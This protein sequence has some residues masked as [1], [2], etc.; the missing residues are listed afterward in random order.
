MTRRGKIAVTAGA[1]GMMLGMWALPP[2]LRWAVAGFAVPQTLA[3]ED[4]DALAAQIAEAV[5]ALAARRTHLLAQREALDRELTDAQEQLT[6]QAG[7]LAGVRAAQTALARTPALG[8][9]RTP[10]PHGGAP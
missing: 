10:A 1:V 7:A 8:A 6:A 9:T 2:P 4:V 3:T 5:T